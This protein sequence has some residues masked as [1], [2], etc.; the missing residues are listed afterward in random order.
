MIKIFLYELRRLLVNK[1]FLGLLLITGWHSYQTLSGTVILG[2]SGTA[3][4]SSWSYGDYLSRILPLT[5]ITLL[6]FITFLFSS[7]EKKVRVL[8]EAT[9]TEPAKYLG[10]KIG[11]I[12][13]GYLLLWCVVIGI[14]L[15]FYAGVF[16]LRDFTGFIAPILLTCIP[17]LPFFLGLGVAVGRAHSGL[18]Y[19]MMLLLLLLGQAP[20]P[21]FL[22]FSGARF[23]MEYPLTLPV[24][25]GG[26]PEFA[27]P[28]SL[29]VQ[30]LLYTLSGIVLFGIGL[31][32][33]Q[34]NRNGKARSNH[35]IGEKEK[36]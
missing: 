19:A 23:F 33:R 15:V 21:Y 13:C 17:A 30:K 32:G 8:T 20:L 7:Q 6:F 18:L 28:A 35:E 29:I 24:G 10:V 36:K 4:F 31:R 14:S 2:T 26:E 5:L 22:D 9:P 1:F 16:R 11:A 25:A 12:A 34:R 3:P 27:V